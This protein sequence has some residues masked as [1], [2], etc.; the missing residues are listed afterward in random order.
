VAATASPQGHGTYA[1]KCKVIYDTVYR[2]VCKTT[3]EKAC[4]T[5]YETKY[6]TTYEKVCT[7]VYEKECK[8]IYKDVP[9]KEC[10]TTYEKSCISVPLTTYTTAYKENC[11]SI[12]KQVKHFLCCFKSKLDF[13]IF[14]FPGLFL[15][16]VTRCYSH[17]FLLRFDT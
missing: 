16:Y 14:Y 12:K 10:S 1:P 6:E 13:L 11:V 4:T 17:Q 5:I 15:C 2:D 8:E 9:H 7:Q 3:Y